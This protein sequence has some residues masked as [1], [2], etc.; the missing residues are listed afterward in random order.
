MSKVEYRF[1]TLKFSF[2]RKI[3]AI[4]KCLILKKC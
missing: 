1:S 4:G 3:M 2:P